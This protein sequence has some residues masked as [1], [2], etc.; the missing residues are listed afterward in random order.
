[1]IFEKTI[2]PFQFLCF[3]F[4]KNYKSECFFSDFIFTLVDF[5][6]VTINFFLVDKIIKEFFRSFLRKEMIILLKK[7][8]N[9]LGTIKYDKFDIEFK[10]LK[11]QK[12]KK[13]FWN[14]NKKLSVKNL[15]R[16]L[17]F[18][19]YSNIQIKQ[20]KLIKLFFVFKRFSIIYPKK[21]I[22]KQLI[23]SYKE[24][25]NKIILLKYDYLS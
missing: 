22:K 12:K 5:L 4:L 9:K 7:L 20:V 16:L 19:N 1:M 25:C 21:N 23:I 3:D 17:N 18:K 11:N 2:K 8:C 24:F 14:L 10:F 6:N 13:Q 15:K